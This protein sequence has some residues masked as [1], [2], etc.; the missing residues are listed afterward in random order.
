MSAVDWTWSPR[1]VPHTIVPDRREA[2]MNTSPRRVYRLRSTVL[3]IVYARTTRD[4]G[5]AGV[6]ATVRETLVW[7]AI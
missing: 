7:R 6:V 4:R 3:T 1:V 5:V 2:R